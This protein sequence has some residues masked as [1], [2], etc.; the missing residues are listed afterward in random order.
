MTTTNAYIGI[1]MT[2]GERSAIESLRVFATSHGE[3][4]FAHMCT[5]ALNGQQWARVRL[6][7]DWGGGLIETNWNG[8]TLLA[9]RTTNSAAP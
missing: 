2:D 4:A 1:S 7:I 3:V 9:I 6:G 8:A 5:E